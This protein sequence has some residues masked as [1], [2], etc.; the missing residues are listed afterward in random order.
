MRSF[1]VFKVV[2][3]HYDPFF[4]LDFTSVT[5]QILL[6]FPYYFKTE[7]ISLAIS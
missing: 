7:F 5:C 2:I 3:F 1:A 6:F 4:S